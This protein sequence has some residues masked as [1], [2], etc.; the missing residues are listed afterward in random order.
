MTSKRRRKKASCKAK[1]TKA[2]LKRFISLFVVECLIICLAWFLFGGVVVVIEGSFLLLVLLLLLLAGR[3]DSRFKSSHTFIFSASF[4]R[5]RRRRRRRPYISPFPSF[6]FPLCLAVWLSCS[7]CCT[8]L[9]SLIFSFVRL[10][11]R[12]HFSSKGGALF[13]FLFR[14][15]D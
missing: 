11:L 8:T 13:S 1:E 2:K 9:T 15:R 12:L 5:L 10:R 6:S 14:V 7:Y 4:C 3:P